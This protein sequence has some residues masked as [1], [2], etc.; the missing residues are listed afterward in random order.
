MNSIMKLL[1]MNTHPQ[2]LMTISGAIFCIGAIICLIRSPD[3]SS[4]WKNWLGILGGTS[5]VLGNLLWHNLHRSQLGTSLSLLGT[6]L[7]FIYIVW[8][9][10]RYSVK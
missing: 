2:M 1:I 8:L 10:I 5:F 7:M 4:A 6:I 3:T 9:M